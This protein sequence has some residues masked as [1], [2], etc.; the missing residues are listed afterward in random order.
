MTR[1]ILTICGIVI[2]AGVGL[3]VG[4]ARWGQQAAQVERAEQRLQTV[5][6]E[7]TA[8]RDQKQQLEQ[9]LEQV[10]KEQERLAH[11]NEVLRQEHATDQLLSGRPG[12][13]PAP[14]PK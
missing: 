4:Y 11:E 9:Q 10:A 6:S 8:L 1:W 2:A 13:L 7:T 12:E 14:P 3:L 5:T